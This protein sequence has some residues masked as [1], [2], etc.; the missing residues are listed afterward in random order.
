M[1]P[2]KNPARSRQEGELSL[3]LKRQNEGDFS[4]MSVDFYRRAQ[5]YNP[6]GIRLVAISAL[7]I[8]LFY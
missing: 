1:K 8:A 7:F 6:E 4:E 3:L 5:R 2:S